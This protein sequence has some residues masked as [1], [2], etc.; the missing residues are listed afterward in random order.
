MEDESIHLICTI[1]SPRL[2][3]S[4]KWFRSTELMNEE[5][6]TPV[7]VNTLTTATIPFSGS[8]NILNGLYEDTYTLKITNFSHSDN[9]SYWC[10]IRNEL[11]N[12]CLIPSAYVNITV[13]INKTCPTVQ[14]E[15]VSTCAES[16]DSSCYT[17]A[18]PSQQ[19]ISSPVSI[20]ATVTSSLNALVV[21]TPPSSQ[22]NLCSGKPKIQNLA[23]VACLG[24]TVPAA[25]F[26]LILALVLICCT[27]V[28]L[29]WR[30]QTRK[31]G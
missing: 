4:V 13:G 30:K 11:G 8:E 28:C 31:K 29:C 18:I 27:G 9:G 20:S 24:V 16:N 6:I 23:F 12:V 2:N 1:Y 10:Q 3:T 26:V 22:L 21:N 17:T 5:D 15:R 19:V 7:Y 14:Y 25:G